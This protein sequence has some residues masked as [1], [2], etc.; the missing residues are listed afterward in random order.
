MDPKPRHPEPA[1]VHEA[2]EAEAIALGRVWAQEKADELRARVPV[3][4][5]PDFWDDANDGPLPPQI[6]ASADLRHAARRAAHER[7][8]ELLADQRSAEANDDEDDQLLVTV[9]GPR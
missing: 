7:W 1:A 6:S 4:E 3:A 2:Y 9:G 8:L 5:W